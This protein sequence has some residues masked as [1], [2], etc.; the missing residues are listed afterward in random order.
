MPPRIEGGLISAFGFLVLLI[1]VFTKILE[2]E[3]RPVEKDPQVS[4]FNENESF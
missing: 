1:V 4:L 2:I 3:E